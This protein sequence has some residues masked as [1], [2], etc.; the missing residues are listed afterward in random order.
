M[1]AQGDMYLAISTYIPVKSKTNQT[2][3]DGTQPTVKPRTT[4]IEALRVRFIPVTKVAFTELEKQRLIFEADA[5][6][7]YL[8]SK[9]KHLYGGARKR[10]IA[11][12]VGVTVREVKLHLR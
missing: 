11:G 3:I 1:Y 7:A 10:W 12:Q 6:A 8:C 4:E 2:K 5:Q 9:G